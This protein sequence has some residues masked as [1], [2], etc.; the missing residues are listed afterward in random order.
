VLPTLRSTVGCL[1]PLSQVTVLPA[2]GSRSP[3]AKPADRYDPRAAP[4]RC[5]LRTARSP[6]G[7]ADGGRRGPSLPQRGS[8]CR[9]SL[10]GCAADCHHAGPGGTWSLERSGHRAAVRSWVRGQP[11]LAPERGYGRRRPGAGLHSDPDR[12][13]CR[14]PAGL[15]RVCRLP[16]ARSRP[17]QP[18]DDVDPAHLAPRSDGSIVAV[19]TE[20]ANVVSPSTVRTATLSRAGRWSTARTFGT[21]SAAGIDV[22]GRDTVHVAWTRA[23]GLVRVSTKR[24]GRAWST[25]AKL[26]RGRVDGIDAARDGST[27]IGYS[28]NGRSCAAGTRPDRFLVRMLSARGGRWSK[29]TVLHSACTMGSGVARDLAAGPGG[30]AVAVVA[31]SRGTYS[32]TRTRR[33]TPGRRGGRG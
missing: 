4:P 25:P 20:T 2:G 15:S 33:G 26:G 8:R 31:S 17:P 6:S 30:K 29:A 3:R 11:R 28:D 5:G 18:G 23:T 32:S 16:Y 19:W 9:G 24:Y 13:R 27:A 21:G 10:T 14:G 22:D 1:E 7:Q 12:R